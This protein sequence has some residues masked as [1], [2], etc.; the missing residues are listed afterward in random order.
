MAGRDGRPRP[1]RRDT[2]LVRCAARRGGPRARCTSPAW[3]A[4]RATPPG[5]AAAPPLVFVAREGH[6]SRR[7]T[8]R[9]PWPSAGAG[10]LPDRS[11]RGSS[12]CRPGK[13]PRHRGGRGTPSRSSGS[14]V[15]RRAGPRP[16][17]RGCGPPARCP[18]CQRRRRSTRR[19]VSLEARASPRA[20]RPRWR[21][22]RCPR[23]ATAALWSGSSAPDG[24]ASAGSPW[25]PA[26]AAG[27][28]A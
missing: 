15:D 23:E 12:R 22:P 8:W 26:Q 7:R 17:M 9:G 14:R 5:S 19:P 6:P 20:P 2:R 24:P 1:R 10:H 18:C 11:G 25:T 21:G 16:S 13:G 4:E 27:S 28:V 3:R